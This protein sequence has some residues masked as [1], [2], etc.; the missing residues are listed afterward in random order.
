M[1]LNVINS[2]KLQQKLS[3]LFSYPQSVLY[4]ISK[5]LGD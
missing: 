4:N 2:H 3:Q 5:V 1:S